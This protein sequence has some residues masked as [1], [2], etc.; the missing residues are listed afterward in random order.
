MSGGGEATLHLPEGRLEEIRL[1][2]HCATPGPYYTRWNG[3]VRDEANGHEIAHCQTLGVAG[4]TRPPLTEEQQRNNARFLAHAWE[5]I[6]YLLWEVE[7]LRAEAAAMDAWAD[8]RRREVETLRAQN[9][10]L[11]G[12]ARAAREG[13]L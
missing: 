7:R 12:E 9:D 6:R 3:E 8:T 1:R 4:N 11:L 10:L 5:D 13:A 2:H